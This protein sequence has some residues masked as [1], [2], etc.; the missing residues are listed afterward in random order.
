MKNNKKETKRE[1]IIKT[2]KQTQIN[3]NLQPRRGGDSHW[4]LIWSDKRRLINSQAANQLQA[5]FE[6]LMH[7][8]GM[9]C[10]F[11]M[12]QS[13]SFQLISFSLCLHTRP[14]LLFFAMLLF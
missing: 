7:F 8:K 6:V 11:V 4:W 2:G 13:H 14:Q 3:K 9:F 1:Q 5:V 10:V 12:V